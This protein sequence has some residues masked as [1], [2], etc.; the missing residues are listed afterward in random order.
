MP[1]SLQSQVV[2]LV[3]T[4]MFVLFFLVV[5]SVAAWTAFS[6]RKDTKLFFWHLFGLQNEGAA[7][8]ISGAVPAV[9]FLGPAIWILGLYFG[10]WH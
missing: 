2:P 5:A 7:T 6:M 4:P 10:L 1:T 3:Q 8:V 9:I